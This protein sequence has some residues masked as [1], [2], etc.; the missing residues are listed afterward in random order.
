MNKNMQKYYRGFTELELRVLRSKK[1]MRLAR[2]NREFGWFND[3]EKSTL[4]Q[5]IKWID[6]ELAAR[7]AQLTLL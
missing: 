2:L 3:R 6:I 1:L 4:N 7:A 5:Q